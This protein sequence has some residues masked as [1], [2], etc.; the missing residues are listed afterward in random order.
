[1]PVGAVPVGAGYVAVGE[2]PVGAGVSIGA[3]CS[4]T[5]SPEGWSPISD[6]GRPVGASSVKLGV[7]T[8][9]T[10]SHGVVYLR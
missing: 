8:S 4:V 2:V 10:V 1:M 9:G 7:L 3:G 6:P 5:A